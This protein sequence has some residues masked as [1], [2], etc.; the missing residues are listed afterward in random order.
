MAVLGPTG[1]ACKDEQLR[2]R[3]VAATGVAI[4]VSR[5]THHVVVREVGAKCKPATLASAHQPVA[6]ES[7]LL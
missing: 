4:Y 7:D 1:E 5:T 3:K 6:D 2:V